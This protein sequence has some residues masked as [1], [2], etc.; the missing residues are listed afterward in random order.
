MTAANGLNR[1]EGAAQTRA[2]PLR[3]QCGRG[4]CD[5]GAAG[6]PITCEIRG[7]FDPQQLAIAA[8]VAL[9]VFLAVHVP[10]RRRR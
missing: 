2:A 1:D 6:A 9:A 4:A 5:A 10:D 8:G 3:G 7:R